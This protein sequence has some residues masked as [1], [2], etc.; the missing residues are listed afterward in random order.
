MSDYIVK[1]IPKDPYY[2][3]PDVDLQSAKSFLQTKLCCGFIEAESNETPVFVDCGGNLE[4]IS[5]PKCS[6]ELDFGWWG[7][8]MDK[9]AEGGFTSLE[10]EMPCCKKVIS[11]N[12]LD[13]YFPCGFASTRIEVFNPAQPI[14]HEITNEMRHILGTDVR[15]VEAHI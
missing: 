12:D 15:V 14:D 7:A 13:Y 5:C 6:A 2:K 3:A 1:I 11:L 4:R 10:T 8:A 9:S